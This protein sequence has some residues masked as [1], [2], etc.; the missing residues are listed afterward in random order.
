MLLAMRNFITLLV[1]ATALA[2][3][4]GPPQ[5]EG[6]AEGQSG[7]GNLSVRVLSE[8]GVSSGEPTA[9]QQRMIAD[10]L[11]AALQALDDDRL[12]T[13]VDDNAHARFKR[14]LAYDSDNELALEGLQNIVVRY[15]ELAQE[16]IRRGLFDEAELMIDRAR[17][18][19]HSHAGINPVV[20]A[21]Q[22]ERNSE[23]LFFNL[24]NGE[25]SNRSDSALEQLADIARQAQ[26]HGA[27]FLITAPNDDQARWM[28]SVMREAVDGYRLRGSIELAGRTTVRLR[29]PTTQN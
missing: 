18:V 8:G 28:F 24:D 2:S 21:L 15:L 25:I 11:Y 27:F 9:D 6:S 17:F 12:L 4:Q 13:P 5:N 7:T 22:S 10:T 3:C 16:S 23:D 19:D 20:E 14:V 1:L 26:Q 29:M